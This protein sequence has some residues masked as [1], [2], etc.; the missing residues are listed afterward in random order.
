MMFKEVK[1]RKGLIPVVTLGIC[2]LLSCIIF[3]IPDISGGTNRVIVLIDKILF[4]DPVALVALLC[5][6]I[7]LVFWFIAVF[8]LL[9]SYRSNKEKEDKVI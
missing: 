8:S 5:L 3:V 2:I 9:S 7:A 4:S 6:G 1:F